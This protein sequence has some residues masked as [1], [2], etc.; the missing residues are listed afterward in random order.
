MKPT[1]ELINCIKSGDKIKAIKLVRGNT[2]FS[3]ANAKRYVDVLE[4]KLKKRLNIV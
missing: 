2:G 1:P 4:A 3:L